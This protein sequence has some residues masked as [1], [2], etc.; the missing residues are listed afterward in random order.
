MNYFEW[1]DLAIRK[2]WAIRI[3]DQ[4]AWLATLILKMDVHVVY[5][6]PDDPRELR[7]LKPGQPSDIET[8][9]DLCVHADEQNYRCHAPD[10]EPDWDMVCLKKHEIY[11]TPDCIDWKDRYA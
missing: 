3:M 7:L 11:E 5:L 9:C 10:Y 6:P 8:Q 4:S 1:H 2:M